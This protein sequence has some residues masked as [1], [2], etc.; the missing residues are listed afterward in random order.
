MIIEA[1]QTLEDQDNMDYVENNGPFKCTRSDAWLGHGF[2]FWDTNIDW[3]HQWGENSY[4]NRGLDYFITKCNIDIN[5]KCFDLFGSVESQKAFREVIE[6]FK[7]DP[8]TKHLKNLNV[9]N[10]ITYMKELGV[11]DYHSIRASDMNNE[12]QIFYR[13]GKEFTLINQRVQICLLNF[14]NTF[15]PPLEVV[16]SK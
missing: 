14:S 15:I 11:F 8:K 9:P 5:Y 3:A 10:V 2:Y 16:Y 7:T 1:Y 4:K 13:K 6:I 12:F